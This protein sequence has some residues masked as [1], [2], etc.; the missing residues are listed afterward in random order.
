M[1]FFVNH[2]DNAENLKTTNCNI[3][4]Q[5]YSKINY[6]K[7]CF[8]PQKTLSLKIIHLEM[9]CFTFK[10]TVHMRTLISKLILSKKSNF[11]NRKK[12]LI[13]SINTK[14]LQYQ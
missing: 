6:Q 4:N 8:P 1:E 11:V 9:V 14:I 13:L 2:L 3:I 5:N 10:M 12:C 7:N